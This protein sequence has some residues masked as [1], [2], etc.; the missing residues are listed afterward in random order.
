MCVQGG[1]SHR[2]RAPAQTG[3]R[4]GRTPSLQSPT[5]EI[6]QRLTDGVF[7][8]VTPRTSRCHTWPRVGCG[9]RVRAEFS[10]HPGPQMVKVP[11]VLAA[12]VSCPTRPQCPAP[13]WARYEVT[14]HTR[15]WTLT[16]FVLMFGK[17]YFCVFVQI[18][19]LTPVQAVHVGL[20]M[21][22][23]PTFAQSGPSP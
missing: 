21:Q 2:V 1:E 18:F 9:L 14:P 19:V 3:L 10:L 15:Q 5:Q 11:E 12:P 4:G 6:G 13:S 16:P 22:S 20:T 17:Q 7:I 8:S 23:V